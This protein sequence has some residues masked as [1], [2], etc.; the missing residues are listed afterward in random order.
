VTPVQQLEFINRLLQVK[1]FPVNTK[2]KPF[3]PGAMIVKQLGEKLNL[4]E[5]VGT[6]LHQNQITLQN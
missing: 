5:N 4:R 2:V 1:C 3:H 6:K